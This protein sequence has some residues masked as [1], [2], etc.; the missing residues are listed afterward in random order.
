MKRMLQIQ[1][2]GSENLSIGNVELVVTKRLPMRIRYE[3][4][5]NLMMMVLSSRKF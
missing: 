5:V 3:T 2:F 4:C 1:I